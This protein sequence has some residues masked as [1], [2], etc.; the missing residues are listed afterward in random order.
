[1]CVFFFSGFS[2]VGCGKGGS[3][4]GFWERWV[5]RGDE[6]GEVGD[7]E[8]VSDCDCLS[9]GIVGV[10]ELGRRVVRVFF[11]FFAIPGRAFLLWGRESSMILSEI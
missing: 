11:D 2:F 10:E 9:S 5:G 7:V 3:W 1:M 4:L 8:G 6:M